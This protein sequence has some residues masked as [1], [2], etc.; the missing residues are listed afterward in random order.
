GSEFDHKNDLHFKKVNDYLSMLPK[1]T[2]EVGEIEFHDNFSIKKW[3]EDPEY[4]LTKTFTLIKHYYGQVD[5]SY[6]RSIMDIFQTLEFNKND[7]DKMNL[8][9][10]HGEYQNT[11]IIF[12]NENIK[13][14]DWDS[15]SIRPQIFDVVASSCYICRDKRGDFKINPDKL[16]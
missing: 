9:I 5:E 10:S 7:Y 3:Y 4:M 2:P 14:I 13:L 12:E 15:L 6:K 11:N 16:R 8:V 1:L